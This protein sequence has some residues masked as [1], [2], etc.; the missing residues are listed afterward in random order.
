MFLHLAALLYWIWINGARW[1]QFAVT[2]NTNLHCTKLYSDQKDMYREIPQRPIR[3]FHSAHFSD[4]FTSL[5]YRQGL[6]LTVMITK[7]IDRCKG[8]RHD[9]IRVLDVGRL[10]NDFFNQVTLFILIHLYCQHNWSL[11]ASVF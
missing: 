9:T 11:T 5:K 2:E 3:T 7:S 8:E 10:I 1:K 4:K 6:S